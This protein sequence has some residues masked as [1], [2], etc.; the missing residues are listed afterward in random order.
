MRMSSTHRELLQSSETYHGDNR[1]TGEVLAQTVVERLVL[2]VNVV[3]LSVLLGDLDLLQS[4]QLV[5]LSFESAN[6]FTNLYQFLKKT[7]L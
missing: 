6:D 1:A 4:N 3:L 5:S 2:Q 7:K